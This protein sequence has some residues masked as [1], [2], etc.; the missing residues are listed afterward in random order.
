ML[1]G[2]KELDCGKVQLQKASTTGSRRSRKQPRFLNSELNCESSLYLFLTITVCS[3]KNRTFHVLIHSE[4]VAAGSFAYTG[5]WGQKGREG[6]WKKLP[7]GFL[8]D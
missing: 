2:K 4:Y 6:K 5:Q 7:A 3:V 8:R 1:V